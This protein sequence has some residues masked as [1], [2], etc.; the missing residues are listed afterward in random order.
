M[1]KSRQDG[2]TA[3]RDNNRCICDGIHGRFWGWVCDVCH[4]HVGNLCFVEVP[5]LAIKFGFGIEWTHLLL[6]ACESEMERATTTSGQKTRPCMG[7]PLSDVVR[8]RFRRVRIA[9]HCRVADSNN[10]QW[11]TKRE[12]VASWEVT[13]A[14]PNHRPSTLIKRHARCTV[15]AANRTQDSISCRMIL[16]HHSPRQCENSNR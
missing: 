7:I 5:A 13:S 2:R 9:N 4:W 12:L 10:R 15:T 16:P 3:I 6:G 14:P 1:I 11:I 8:F